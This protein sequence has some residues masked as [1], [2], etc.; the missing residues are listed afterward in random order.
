METCKIETREYSI[1]GHINTPQTGCIPLVDIPQM[2]DERWSQ[3]AEAAAVHGFTR[4][5]GHPPES[6]EIA[7]KWQAEYLKRRC[8][9]DSACPML[10]LLSA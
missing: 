6:V 9:D 7:V 1:S 4:H 8:D 5:F 2:S 3:L 10:P